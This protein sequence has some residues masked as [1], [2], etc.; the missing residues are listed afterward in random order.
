MLRGVDSERVGG[1][2]QETIVGVEIG[3]DKEK[4]REKM[5]T[6]EENYEFSF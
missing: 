3:G 4:E 5:E 2:L 6:D 1:V